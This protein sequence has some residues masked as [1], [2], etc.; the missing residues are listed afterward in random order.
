MPMKEITMNQSDVLLVSNKSIHLNQVLIILAFAK[1]PLS[2]FVSG[3]FY[4]IPVL[5]S[6]SGYLYPSAILV[7]CLLNIRYIF[8]KIRFG[9]LCV[10]TLLL[11][12]TAASYLLYPNSRVYIAQHLPVLVEE[13]MLYYILGICWMQ[14]DDFLN[15]IYYTSILSI[16]I[17]FVYLIFV[18]GARKSM[19]YNMP[20][21]YAIMP[22]VMMC[23]LF[24]I[25]KRIKKAFVF[26]A[27]GSFLLLF[28]GARGPVVI[29]L[30][31]CAFLLWKKSRTKAR[32]FLLGM[33]IILCWIVM[34]TNILPKTAS[35]LSEYARRIGLSTRVFDILAKGE[36]FSY[37]SGRDLLYDISR[38]KIL[39][40]PI[41]G[42]GIYGEWQFIQNPTHRIWLE[43]WMHYGI[44]FG[45]LLIVCM[46][47]LMINGIVKSKTNSM[48][49]VICLWSIF[50]VVRGIFGGDYLSYYSSLLFG[51]C[52]NSIRSWKESVSFYDKGMKTDSS[53]H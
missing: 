46:I 30:C 19:N 3:F 20:V 10:F 9:D 27:L 33:A 44:I 53:I 4:H 51:L 41:F 22:S 36:M 24:A 26:M 5:A 12:I 45:T 49:Q 11:L 37:I 15:S 18:I 23:S 1:E 48:R 21:A 31:Y 38:R 7:V 28:L 13:V 2:S 34:N 29:Q 39:E 25:D 43:I 50:F 14:D 47:Y 52:V 6:I 42:Y 8:S 40:N 35:M 16:I 17:N 32:L